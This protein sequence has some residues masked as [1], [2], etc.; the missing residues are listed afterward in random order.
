MSALA[1]PAA[2]DLDPGDVDELVALRDEFGLSAGDV[3]GPG[4]LP[5]W[6]VDLLVSVAAARVQ[7][8]EGND[9]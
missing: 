6:E 4:A 1:G 5:A 9:A 2:G 3:W 7:R 8:D